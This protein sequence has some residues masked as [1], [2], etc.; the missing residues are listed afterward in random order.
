MKSLLV[1]IGL[2][3]GV[4]LAVTSVHASPVQWTVENG[5]NGHWYD[6][7]DPGVVDGVTWDWSY[8]DAVQK[9]GYLATLTSQNEYAFVNGVIS[10][11]GLTWGILWIGASEQYDAVTWVN[12]EGPVDVK[13]WWPSPWKTLQPL[14]GNY[15][16]VITGS[17]YD[18]V[19][20]TRSSD[21]V[22]GQ[23]VLE[24]DAVPEPSTYVLLVL[25]L[26]VVGYVRKRMQQ[27]S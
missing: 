27:Q 10:N 5:G 7:V 14:V 8:A 21:Q 17:G 9:G 13:G 11:Y 3:L 2:L 26:G 12:G 23:Y 4:A 16:V 18:S 6:V 1:V 22:Q 19:W 25:S 24:Y 15:G 20:D